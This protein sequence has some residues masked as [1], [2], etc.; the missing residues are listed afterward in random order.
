MALY[1]YHPVINAMKICFKLTKFF[2]SV[3]AHQRAIFQINRIKF[4]KNVTLL[5]AR[6]LDLHLKIA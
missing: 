1:R 5:A 4:A 6:V 2:A 3:S